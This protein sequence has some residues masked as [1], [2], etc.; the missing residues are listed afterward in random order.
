MQKSRLSVSVLGTS[1]DLE[2]DQQDEYVQSIY[3][4]YLS[5]LEKA[6]ATSDV[7]DPLKIAIIA[8]LFLSDEVF[9]A[10]IETTC[11]TTDPKAFIDMET[12][13]MRMIAKI[14]DIMHDGV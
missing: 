11:T 3:N 12:T 1:F 7:D 5:V 9:K 13:T 6:K 4:Y 8:G 10:R 14:D 2:A